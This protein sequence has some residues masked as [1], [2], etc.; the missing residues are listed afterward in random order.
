VGARASQTNRRAARRRARTGA[1]RGTG[2]PQL[3]APD[4]RQQ[5][6]RQRLDR[7]LE[8]VVTDARHDHQSVRDRSVETEAQRQL[9]GGTGGQ[10]E[11]A[12]A[13]SVRLGD[14][15]TDAAHEPIERHTGRGPQQEPH[16]GVLGIIVVGDR[17]VDRA[18]R[19]GED[20][21]RRRQ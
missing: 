1:E 11:R 2:E 5:E 10:R 14:A 12:P 19:A 3:G 20:R 13:R 21:R 7:H 18:R 16:R 4:L 9:G 6:A 17:C 15:R 8:H